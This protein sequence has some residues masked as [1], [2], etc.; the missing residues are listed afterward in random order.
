MNIH[1]ER[2]GFLLEGSNDNS[3]WTT[4][5]DDKGCSKVIIIGVLECAIKMMMGSKLALEHAF[6][7]RP[8]GLT[9]MVE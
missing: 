8:L 5:S 6:K 7:W 2:G 9:L 1:S 4:I 3:N